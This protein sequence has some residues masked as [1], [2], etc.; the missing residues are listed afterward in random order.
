MYHDDGKTYAYEQ[1]QSSTSDRTFHWDDASR[2]ETDRGG[3]LSPVEA[4]VTGGLVA[5]LA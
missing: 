4:L 5:R 2:E 1:G 3:M